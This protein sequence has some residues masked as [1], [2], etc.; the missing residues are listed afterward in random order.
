MIRSAENVE[1]TT[2]EES[3]EGR[4]ALRLG[5]ADL[6]L[7]RLDLLDRMPALGPSGNTL[8]R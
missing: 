1:R 3:A 8:H 2:T 5:E 6:L 7:P 4:S